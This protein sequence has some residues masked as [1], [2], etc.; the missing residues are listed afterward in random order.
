MKRTR[1][2]VAA[3]ARAFAKEEAGIDAE[4]DVVCLIGTKR[5]PQHWETMFYA[6]TLLPEEERQGTT[7]IDGGELWLRIDD[8]TGTVCRLMTPDD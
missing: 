6:M 5:K 4:P 2:E 1:E 7:T 8:A 3:I